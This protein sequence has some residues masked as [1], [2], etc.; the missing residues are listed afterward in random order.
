MFLLFREVQNLIGN[1]CK[2]RMKG[3]RLLYYF[4]GAGAI[5]GKT[6]AFFQESGL[7]GFSKDEAEEFCGGTSTFRSSHADPAVGNFGRSIGREG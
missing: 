2:A 4:S 3:F 6:M 5:G 1:R 7:N